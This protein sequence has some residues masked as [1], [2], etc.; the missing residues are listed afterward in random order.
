MK[1]VRNSK[2]VLEI[3]KSAE[4]KSRSPAVLLLYHSS[5]AVLL[6]CTAHLSVAAAGWSARSLFFTASLIYAESTAVANSLYTK[7]CDAVTVSSK[8]SSHLSL[9][10]MNIYIHP[11]LP[12]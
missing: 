11:R 1:N 5:A 3:E 12:L 2:N 6:Y 7:S 9:P 4:K 10:S 8:P